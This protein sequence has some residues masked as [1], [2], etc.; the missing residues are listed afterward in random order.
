MT[1]PSASCW[2]SRP[3]SPTA[4]SIRPTSATSPTFGGGALMDIGCYP[5]NVAG[6]MFDGEPT[7]WPAVVRRDPALRHRRARR[8]PCSTSAA[9]TP[10]SRAR[11]SSR[12]TSGST[13]SAPPG[14]CWSRSRSTSR[15]IGRRASSAP[16]AVHRRSSPASRSSR[17]R[18]PTRTPCRATPSPPPSD[19]GSR[20]R[21]RPSDAVANMVVHRA[22]P[23]LRRRL[24][25]RRPSSGQAARVIARSVRRR[26]GGRWAARF[27]NGSTSGCSSMPSVSVMNR[28]RAWIRC[29]ASG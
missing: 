12:T 9:A 15:P 20:C 13:S 3:S 25:R 8:R 19:R 16:P 28:R 23:G 6:W 1:V 4:T 26:N 18:R 27:E 29:H 14:G 7:R 22:D 11:P 10:R 5:I 21:P 2:R 17:S 24:N